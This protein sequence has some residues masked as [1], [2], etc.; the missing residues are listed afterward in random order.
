MLNVAPP[1]RRPPRGRAS[2]PRSWSRHSGGPELGRPDLRSCGP[3]RRSRLPTDR[4]RRR[5]PPAQMPE[6][7]RARFRCRTRSRTQ[8]RPRTLHRF[9]R[10]SGTSYSWFDHRLHRLS[11]GRC[12]TAVTP[13]LLGPFD[14]DAEVLALAL[15]RVHLAVELADPDDAVEER[16]VAVVVED[17]VAGGR[18][19][20]DVSGGGIVSFGCTLNRQLSGKRRGFLDAVVVAE[21]EGQRQLSRE[22]ARR[23]VVVQPRGE[24]CIA[25]GDPNRRVG[26]GAG[27]LVAGGGLG[28]VDGALASGAP[29]P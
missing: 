9:V 19:G 8:P 15:D 5:P 7:P 16:G 22:I 18:P 10:R 21:G 13:R 17:Q 26:R 28:L 2:P 12:D 25:D 11:I 23:G 14:R 27:V 20:A 24:L 1:L 6:P 4:R 29:A 3:S